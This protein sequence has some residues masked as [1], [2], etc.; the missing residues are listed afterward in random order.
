MHYCNVQSKQ[1]DEVI[2]LSADDIELG[3]FQTYLIWITE[4]QFVLHQYHTVTNDVWYITPDQT[5]KAKLDFY[6]DKLAKSAA[7]KARNQN[8]AIVTN[9]TVGLSRFV[10]WE[11][12]LPF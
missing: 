11:C 4:Y 3:K 8:V 7:A 1:F 10:F 2:Y 12:S 6:L 9:G 5:K